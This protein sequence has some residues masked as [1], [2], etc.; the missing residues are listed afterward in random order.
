MHN[1]LARHGVNRASDV[2]QK[3][4]PG[5]SSPS[6][7]SVFAAHESNMATLL[8]FGAILLW[9]TLATLTAL[10]GPAVPPFQTTAITFGVGGGVLLAIAV[11]RGRARALSPNPKAFALALYGL[12]AYHALYFAALR[13]APAAEANLIASLWAL[14][15]VLLSGLL[16]G[17]RLSAR[18][19]VAALLGLGAAALLV[20]DIGSA[21]DAYPSR[22]LGIAL[23]FACAFVWASYSVLSR[24]VAAIPSESLALPCLATSALAVIASA[25]FETWADVP[26]MGSW[27]ALILL[28]VGPVGA[29]FLLW[30][31]GMKHGHIATLGVLAYASPIIS[32][33]LLVLLGLARP[34]MALAA[35]CIMMVGAAALA[36]RSTK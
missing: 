28:G 3:L 9:S 6:A 10:K 25:A 4:Q 21:T 13:L 12:F 1:F 2:D 8:G 27:L 35:A 24:L 36:V 26:S 17:H 7:L 11:L 20:S 23:A 22:I 14:L 32:T 33:A 18:H 16:P 31:I 5:P 30:D 29:A 15:T 34:S 19:V